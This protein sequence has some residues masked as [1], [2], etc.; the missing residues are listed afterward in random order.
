MSTKSTSMSGGKSSSSART[1]KYVSV[2]VEPCRG[3]DFLSLAIRRL[4]WVVYAEDQT[5]LAEESHSCPSRPSSPRVHDIATGG[6]PVSRS[7][8]D[9]PIGRLPPAFVRAVRSLPPSD[10]CVAAHGMMRAH[11]LLRRKFREAGMQSAWDDLQKCCTRSPELLRV[12]RDDRAIG[13]ACGDD[14]SFAV[15]ALD[16]GRVY[17]LLM[18]P[19]GEKQAS[20][21]SSNPACAAATALA[22]EEEARDAE[23]AL[24]RARKTGRVFFWYKN[25]PKHRHQCLEWLVEDFFVLNGGGGSGRLRRVR[26]LGKRSRDGDSADEQQRPET[27][28]IKQPRRLKRLPPEEVPDDEMRRMTVEAR[29]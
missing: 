16:L 12:A 15:P 8:A 17:D 25:S 3:D 4:S 19:D 20:A 18:R 22:E 6:A 1:P 29:A 28:P 13:S 23:E 10:G 14:G 24:D 27:P 11:L 9:R 21:S 26:R 5:V 2:Y 7:S